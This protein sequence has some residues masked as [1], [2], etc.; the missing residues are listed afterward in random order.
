VSAFLKLALCFFTLLISGPATAG[1]RALEQR[2]DAYLRPLLATNNFS[3]VVLVA[4]G[5]RIIF[6]KGYGQASIEHRVANGPN[7]IFQIAS[8]SKPFTSAAIMLMADEGRIGL[9]SPL[10]AILPDYPGGDRLTIHHLLTH[11]SGI[12]NVNDF[13]EYEA[14][15]RIPHSPAELV[16]HFKDRPLEFEPGERYSY[17]NSN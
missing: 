1:Q 8:V 16:A 2:V 5:D 10:T 7:T 6:Q 17:S 11:T 15:Q 12:P 4:K 9:H 3:G 14:L 13:P